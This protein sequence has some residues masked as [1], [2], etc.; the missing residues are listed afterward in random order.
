M[1]D[2][3][4]YHKLLIWEKSH[5]LALQI[6]KITKDFPKEEIYSLTSQLRRATTS[7]PANIV[8]GHARSSK[9]EFKQFLNIA[10]G[11]LTEV[12]Y[13][14]ELARDLGYLGQEN[15][16]KLEKLRSEV[17]YLLFKFIKSL[18]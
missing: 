12:E 14:L 6:Y 8:E 2:N 18:N 5:E 10:I 3:K 16:N 9:K 13:Y 4:A 15:Y 17:G 1:G 11:S 7:V